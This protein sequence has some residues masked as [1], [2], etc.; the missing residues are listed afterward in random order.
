MSESSHAAP[1][2]RRVTGAR[3]RGRTSN[4]PAKE[5]HSMTRS[6][7]APQPRERCG[8]CGTLEDYCHYHDH[9]WGFPVDDDRRL[10]RR[11]RLLRQALEDDRTEG[12]RRQRCHCFDAA[13]VPQQLPQACAYRRRRTR[14]PRKSHQET[15]LLLKFNLNLSRFVASQGQKQAALGQPLFASRSVPLTYAAGA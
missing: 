14:T 5:P 12:L 9:E 10:G 11:I 3:S 13:A 6:T 8:W 1:L 7:S 2:P 4:R 15:S